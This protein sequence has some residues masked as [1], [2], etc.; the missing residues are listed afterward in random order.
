MIKF[1]FRTNKIFLKYW[2]I[3]NIDT[4]SKESR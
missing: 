4:Q 3:Q 1:E 2:T